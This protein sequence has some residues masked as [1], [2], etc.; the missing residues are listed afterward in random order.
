MISKNIVT[1]ELLALE[2]QARFD[3]D[4]MVVPLSAVKYSLEYL[5]AMEEELLDKLQ[6]LVLAQQSA[7]DNTVGIIKRRT[8]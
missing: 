8:E 3:G 2:S 1:E 7:R 6:Q 4:E 5:S